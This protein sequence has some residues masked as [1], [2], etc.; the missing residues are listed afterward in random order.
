[1]KKFSSILAML[2]VALVIC[3][4]FAACD[5]GSNDNGGTPTP[6]PTKFEGEWYSPN[7]NNPAE[8]NFFR[9]SG[10]SFEFH[11]SNDKGEW[12][13]NV[14]GTFIFTTTSITFSYS[15]QNLTLG[16]TLDAAVKD[17]EV[18]NVNTTIVGGRYGGRRA[19]ASRDDFAGTWTCLYAESDGVKYTDYS[20]VFGEGNNFYFTATHPNGG[21]VSWPG[22]FTYTS[23]EITFTPQQA[24]TWT[25]YKAT[26]YFEGSQTLWMDAPNH[27]GTMFAKR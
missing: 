21:Y 20:Y 12:Y 11:R 10:D 2:T 1:M 22:S 14:T 6:T 3:L 23:T 13:Y 7:P 8:K 27:P 15:G 16:Y 9:F 25:G 17:L 5:N 18:E 26:Y 19:A 24:G 4:V